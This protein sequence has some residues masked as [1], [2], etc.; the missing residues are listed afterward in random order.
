MWLRVWVMYAYVKPCC[1]R[2]YQTADWSAQAV[3]YCLHSKTKDERRSRHRLQTLC[4]FFGAQTDLSRTKKQWYLQ[5]VSGV[6][7]WDVHRYANK[8]K[9][10]CLHTTQKSNIS[11]NAQVGLEHLEQ[12]SEKNNLKTYCQENKRSCL[13]AYMEKYWKYK[14]QNEVLTKPQ[15]GCK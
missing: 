11:I 15:V 8:T 10:N 7:N 13:A 14:E 1:M 3:K 2:W 5:S 12:P 4:G 6:H 9:Q